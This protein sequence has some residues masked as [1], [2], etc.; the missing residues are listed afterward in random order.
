M[1][2]KITAENIVLNGGWPRFCELR[3]IDLWAITEG[4]LDVNYEFELEEWEVKE[5]KE[6]AG[7]F[8]KL[9]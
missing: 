1:K 6:S 5:L 8:W 9:D 4:K 7:V 3:N 2:R